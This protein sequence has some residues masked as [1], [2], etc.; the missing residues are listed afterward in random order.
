MTLRSAARRRIT[1]AAAA[2]AIFS[3]VAF[4]AHAGAMGGHRG[5]HT[6]MAPVAVT[7][8]TA[9]DVP[10]STAALLASLFARLQ[11][12]DD[13][14]LTVEGRLA[15]TQDRTST[16]IGLMIGIGF[17][18]LCLLAAIL[19]VTVRTARSTATA[20]AAL[21]ILER[22]YV[23]LGRDSSLQRPAELGASAAVKVRFDIALTNHGRT[24]AVIRWLNLNGQFL[25]EAPEG[26]YED[27]ERHGAGMVIGAGQTQTVDN[28]V[29]LIP[30]SDWDR[31]A[32]GQGGVFLH[33]RIVY[34]DIF[35]AQHETYFCWRYDINAA[36]FRVVESESLNR[37]D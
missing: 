14:V 22:A 5:G 32:A 23:F 27:H 37:H 19:L 11:N 21:P 25:G 31:A 13:R 2:A 1:A 28:R 7:P 30:R 20:T 24:P 17:V 35:G 12:Q 33:G 4:D 29:A 9:P 3:L 34:S 10:P 8:P 18:Q 26:Q 6:Y 16:L 15:E 36:V